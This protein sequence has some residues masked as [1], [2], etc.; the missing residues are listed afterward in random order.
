MYNDFKRLDPKAR[1]SMTIS[2]IIFLIVISAILFAIRFVLSH[3]RIPKPI[4]FWYDTIAIIVVLFQ[5]LFVFLKPT[6]GYKRHRYRINDE[7]IEKVT[8]IFNICHEIIPIR[9][10]QQINVNQGP[11]NRLFSLATI[12]IIT[13]GSAQTIDFIQIH[14]ANEIATKLKSEINDF[15]TKQKKDG[16]SN[17]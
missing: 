6:I 8:G 17:E 5:A 11:I 13:A 10:M 12:E 14:L 7:S 3:Y 4:I 9:R 15:A 16:D 1:Y 2:A